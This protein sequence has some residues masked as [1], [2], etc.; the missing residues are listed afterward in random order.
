MNDSKNL[1]FLS[2]FHVFLITFSTTAQCSS[3][4]FL[5][6]FRF[7]RFQEN[8]ASVYKYE[9]F[10][11]YLVGNVG[12]YSNDVF[13]DDCFNKDFCLSKTKFQRCF[14]SRLTCKHVQC[15]IGIPI[16]IYL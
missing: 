9:T 12:N 3:G 15:N 11:Y 1:L 5:F 8:V 4:F 6:F 16:N 14:S 10:E 13:L 2:F 7:K